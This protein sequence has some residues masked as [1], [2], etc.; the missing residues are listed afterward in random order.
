MFA[1]ILINGWR[2]FDS[3]DIE[4]HERLTVLTGANGA[5]KSTILKLLKSHFPLE[6]DET[7]LALPKNTET[8][9]SFFTGIWNELSSVGNW[10][11][12]KKV[13]KTTDREVGEI[14]YIKADLIC[15]LS[16]EDAKD[17]NYK[18]IR[19]FSQK[20]DGLT[21]S[22][23]HPEPTYEKV[24]SIPIGEIS[25]DQAFEG[26][27][28]LKKLRGKSSFFHGQHGN[29]EVL[30]A[31]KQSLIAFANFGE[32]NKHVKARADLSGLFDEFQD[33]LKKV[34]PAEIGF[35]RLEVRIPEIVVVTESGDFPVDAA[36][37]GL[38]AI[39]LTAWQLFLYSK[40]TTNNFVAL[41][42]EPEN[43]LH[44]AMQRIFLS[45][46]VDAF[47]RA[48]FVVATHSPFIISSVRDSYIYALQHNNSATGILRSGE[49]RS[50]GS[51]KVD[52]NKAGVATKI[53]REVLGVPVTMPHWSEGLLEKVAQEFSQKEL[54]TVSIG[55]LKKRLKDEG[56]EEFYPD[57]ISKI[58]GIE[59]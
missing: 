21:I 34:L 5:G 9:V 57:A 30:F 48:Q 32:G 15:K 16:T 27:H 13:K 23:H 54:N 51:H 46:L 55:M 18:I 42:D 10:F 25:P 47:P 33:I 50:I 40:K 8:G 3:I 49:P 36:S 26:F 6:E 39:M 7:F 4:F 22:S 38:M 29:F 43:H 2:Q 11:N 53:L 28:Q 41:I 52:V 31:F 37:G 14:H 58:I 56:L 44:P 59:Q 19:S 35:N 1:K 24:T 20:I 45:G 12:R 17:I